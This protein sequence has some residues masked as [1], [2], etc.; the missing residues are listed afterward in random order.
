MN[1]AKQHN[2]PFSYEELLKRI[3]EK[4]MI[5]LSN[6]IRYKEIT[7][8]KIIIY[9]YFNADIIFNYL[10]LLM[11][12]DDIKGNRSNLIFIVNELYFYP[13]YIEKQIISSICSYIERNMEELSLL[14]DLRRV[15]YRKFRTGEVNNIILNDV[16]ICRDNKYKDKIN[17][18]RDDLVLGRYMDDSIDFRFRKF[19]YFINEG[20]HFPKELI[21]AKD[22]ENRAYY[23]EMERGN[24]N[25]FVDEYNAEFL[26]NLSVE[27]K[28][29]GYDY[30]LIQ[31]DSDIF[32]KIN[33]IYNN[34]L[35]H[36][37]SEKVSSEIITKGYENVRFLCIC[38]RGK[39]EVIKDIND[40]LK[41][42]VEII[43]LDDY[44]EDFD[45]KSKNH[46]E[47]Y[48]DEYIG[49]NNEY[50]DNIKRRI[51]PQL[52]RIFGGCNEP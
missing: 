40:K 24:Y 16:E 34:I 35:S 14:C 52:D 8:K 31:L 43:D 42:Q 12:N 2:V 7:C 29:Y 33:Q 1:V 19:M 47:V 20:R 18:Y 46:S 22:L 37:I 10:K 51:L 17:K 9:K 11:T 48:D 6:S 38:D 25:N 5:E 49:S 21:I 28:S 4:V 39:S 45:K 13:R 36:E 50:K 3:E 41:L 26:N 32:T 30:G 23:H 44:K 15:R 27:I